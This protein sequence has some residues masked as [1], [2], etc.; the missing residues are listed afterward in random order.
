VKIRIAD[1][2]EHIEQRNRWRTTWERV[3]GTPK[4]WSF[5][6]SMYAEITP[7]IMAG[8]RGDKYLVDWDFT[9]IERDLWQS[10]RS[11]GLPFWPQYPVGR[12]FVDFADPLRRVALECDGK[13]WHDKKRDADRD[14]EL[15]DLGWTV[16]RFPGWQCFKGEDD[17]DSAHR[18]LLNLSESY[19][20][21]CA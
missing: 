2:L 9:P 3:R 17:E 6:R 1:V 13:Q 20:P 11:L 10:I 19:Y 14:A 5:I 4:Q 16:H 21:A 12:F 8:E 18:R 15:L 7:E